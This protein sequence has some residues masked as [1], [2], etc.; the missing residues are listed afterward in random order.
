MDDLK[1][2]FSKLTLLKIEKEGKI[3]SNKKTQNYEK[4]KSNE[5]RK[6][7]MKDSSQPDIIMEQKVFTVDVKKKGFFEFAVS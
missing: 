1:E 6:A 3:F 5:M 2:N 7:F 4:Q